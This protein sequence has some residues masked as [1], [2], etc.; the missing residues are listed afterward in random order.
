[1]KMQ[2]YPEIT[3]KLYVGAFFLTPIWA[4]YHKKYLV[5][6]LSVIP[7]VSLLASFSALVYGGKWAWESRD[8]ETENDFMEN[9][10]KW[11]IAGV[12]TCCVLV[13]IKV[14]FF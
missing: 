13:L 10:S 7:I 4:I 11:N 14:I 9:R 2:T 12:L 5:F 1:M 8:W 6:I 3:E